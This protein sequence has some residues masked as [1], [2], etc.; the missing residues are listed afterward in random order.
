ME[1][2]IE[3]NGVELCTEPFGTPAT[4]RSFW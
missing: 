1:R 3:T 2:L 4:H